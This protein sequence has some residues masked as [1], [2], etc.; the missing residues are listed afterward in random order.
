MSRLPA[1]A[2]TLAPGLWIGVAVFAGVLAL[3][4]LALSHLISSPQ[5]APTG[6]D[7]AFYSH[8]AERILGGE[9]SDGRAFYAL[10]LFAY[11]L[12]ALYGIFGVS[13]FFP[14]LLQCTADAGTALLL[15]NLTARL[16]DESQPGDLSHG[17]K[18][19]GGLA[20]AIWAFYLPAQAFSIVLMPT[21][22]G[23]FVFWFLVWQI[24]GKSEP[25]GWLACLL[26]GLLIGIT[27]MAVA[28]I[29]FAIPL[30]LAALIW[31]WRP[32]T[33][34]ITL[35]AVALLGGVALGT[36]PCWLHNRF[37]AKDGVFLSAHSGVNF[38]IGNNPDANG[39]PRFGEVRAGQAE[40]LRDSVAVAEQA[41]GKTLTRGEVS[42]FWSAK[43][44]AYIASD[45]TGWLRLIG[46][47]V[48][49]FWNAF[50]YDDLSVVGKLRE[51]GVI[52]PGIRFGLLAALALAGIPFALR[53]WPGSRWI[54]AA[55]GLH[56]LALL[57]VFIT[58]RY[59]LAAAP[60][61]VIFAVLG[62]R[63]FWESCARIRV[64][65][66][67]VY[68]VLLALAA[69]LVSW[70]PTEPA[71]WALDPY[72]AGREALDA[73]D[74][75]LAQR[76]LE[77]A[78]SYV[79]QS[80]EINLALGNLWLA[81]NDR[82]AAREF[83][84]DTLAAQPEHKSALNNLGVLALEEGDFFGAQVYLRRALRAD[85]ANAKSHYLLARALLGA[86]DLKQA[87]AEIAEAIRLSPEQP[88]F[89]SLY[90]KLTSQP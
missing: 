21:V 84:R 80:A 81:R 87:R 53:A 68:L 35:G 39:Y 55:V 4:L 78:H 60:G 3:R 56:M 36:S 76:K 65:A 57:P 6:G 49:N 70:S 18:I 73:G 79:P 16:F 11:W 40:M 64:R 89:R 48:W 77:L 51:Q 59:R 38:W 52:F 17:G 58:E 83:Y 27:A 41:A 71:L 45:V 72:N 29:L 5:A 66:A 67:A 69:G 88:E 37:V 1:R 43:A 86:G 25:P 15:Y 34:A 46:R 82:G 28:T 44:R 42:E 7:I 33:K 10:P 90:E 9:W 30:L 23:V 85:P 13:S 19:A 31:K 14:G 8:W 63:H 62:L 61:L 75:P 12:A 2:R 26:W 20:A 22:L 50:Q 24:I 74:L 47:K 32:G 54:L